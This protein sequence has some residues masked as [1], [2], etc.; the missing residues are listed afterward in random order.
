MSDPRK[1]QE[2]ADASLEIAAENDR[3]ASF[4]RLRTSSVALEAAEKELRLLPARALVPLLKYE[5]HVWVARY[6]D[7]QAAGMSPELALLHFCHQF[8]ATGVSDVE[9]K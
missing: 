1:A 3:M 7:L 4:N 2:R 6:G 8:S 5:N 9:T